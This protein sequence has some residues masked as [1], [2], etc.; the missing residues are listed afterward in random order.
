MT[1]RPA[2]P[3]PTSGRG[4]EPA[5]GSPPTVAKNKQRTEETVGAGFK[6]AQETP[7]SNSQTGLKPIQE[8]PPP[9]NRA[10]LKPA[11]TA[12]STEHKESAS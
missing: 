9:D 3:S 7:L 6:P 12:D 10:G 8:T 1:G 2:S 4:R 5:A 11:P